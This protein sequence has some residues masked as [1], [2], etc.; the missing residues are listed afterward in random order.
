MECIV[1]GKTLIGDLK[2]KFN[3]TTD[4]QLSLHIGLTVAVIRSWKNQDNITTRQFS[5][6]IAESIKCGE[7]K[8]ET[9]AIRPI[10]EFFELD[11]CESKGGARFEIFN[12][13]MN[14]SVHTY[15][16]GLRTELEA[17]HGVYVFFDSRGHAIYAGKARKLSLWTEMTSAFNRSRSLQTIKRVNHPA[18][19]VPYKTSEEKSR[20]I[21]SK[22]VAIHEIAAYFSAYKVADGMVD[23]LEAML[24]RSFANDLLNI[25]MERFG[26]QRKK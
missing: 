18:R 6:L 16:K 13:I 26:S 20:Q 7:K 17:N 22:S 24:V 23:E 21:V 8:A 12:V 2:K 19:N 15:L 5:N 14:G 25:R 9:G 11:K 3:V 1:D 4:K 10:V